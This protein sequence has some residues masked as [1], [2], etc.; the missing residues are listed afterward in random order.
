VHVLSPFW[1]SRDALLRDVHAEPHVS[2]ASHG[3][4]AAV[5]DHVLIKT[6]LRRYGWIEVGLPLNPRTLGHDIQDVLL[7]RPV[8][9]RLDKLDPV[10]DARR[11][12]LGDARRREE[13][14][15]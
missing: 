11:D 2:L 13:Q 10:D 5:L 4:A 9:I 6:Q 7:E 12:R 3:V 8:H 14:Q 1:I 15:A